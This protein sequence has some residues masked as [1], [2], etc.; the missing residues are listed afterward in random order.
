[1]AWCLV[2][3]RDNFMIMELTDKLYGLNIVTTE[4]AMASR[5][6]MMN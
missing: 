5:R 4:M 2:K 1:M 3:H 6:G